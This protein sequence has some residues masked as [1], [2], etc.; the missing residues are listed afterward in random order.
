MDLPAARRVVATLVLA[1][2]AARARADVPLPHRSASE[3]EV[4][5]GFLLNFARF[6]EWPPDTFHGPREPFVIAV[7]GRDPFGRVLDQTM[8]GKTVDG[9]RIEVRRLSRVDDVREAQI[10]FVCP[11]ER[12]NLAS[13]LKAL[14]RPGV[15]IVGDTDG[16]ADHGGHINF[17]VQA[18]KVRFE[19]NPG[20]A[21]QSRL[22]VSSQ[23]LKLATLVAGP[24]S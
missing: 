10:V 8:A 12:E 22:K 4:K 15:L 14:D 2:V 11:S 21:E 20:R 6:V 17:I 16:F 1:M 19:I 18:H 9:R 3:Y 7:L 23:L 5:A 24:R 13:I